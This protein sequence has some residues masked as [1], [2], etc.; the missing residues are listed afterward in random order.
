[1]QQKSYFIHLQ[2]IAEE[3]RVKGP[4]LLKNKNNSLFTQPEKIAMWWK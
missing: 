3:R 2:R 4:T 1:M